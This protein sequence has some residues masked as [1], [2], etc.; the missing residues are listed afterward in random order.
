MRTQWYADRG[1][2]EVECVGVS[3]KKLSVKGLQIYTIHS[4]V[5][6]LL[7]GFCMINPASFMFK[8]SLV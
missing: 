8:S 2:C 3:V 1:R 6:N 7:L 5:R 4:E